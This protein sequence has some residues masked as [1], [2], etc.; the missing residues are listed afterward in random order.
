MTHLG[1]GIF[2]TNGD[3]S[4]STNH[5]FRLK[6]LSFERVF[7]SF[8]RNKR[9]FLSLLELCREEKIEVFRL[10]SN[11]IPYASHREFKDKWFKELEPHIEE[12]GKR[13]LNY[14]IR[15]TMHPGQFVILNSPN[16]RVIENSLRELN[17]HFWLLD[18]LGVGQDGVVIV[19]IGGVYGEKIRA[20]ESFINTVEKNGWLK[21]RL[22]IEND[23][24]LFNAKDVL[25]IAR[26]L[27]IPFVFDFFHHRLN[28]S[29]ILLEEVFNT[30]KNNGIP[31][32]HLSS[33][34]DGRY[35]VHGDYVKVE[36]FLSLKMLIEATGIEKVHIM[37]E[38][39]RKENALKKLREELIINQERLQDIPSL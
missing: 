25:E 19:H 18:K 15:I 2:C 4:L 34:G 13:V 10:G 38:A 3:G 20:I 32:V 36:D 7:E 21:R 33:D 35:G 1:F 29:K 12:L 6:N 23:E 8:N 11:F 14:R 30:W 22:A 37:I 27:K 26:V 5:S 24:R 9:D 17:Y 31:K 39:K 16:G 28:P